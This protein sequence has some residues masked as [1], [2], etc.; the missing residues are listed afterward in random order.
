[1]LIWSTHSSVIVKFFNSS[2]VW[3]YTAH[4]NVGTSKQD[5]GCMRNSFSSGY[6]D[7]KPMSAPTSTRPTVISSTVHRCPPL[8]LYATAVSCEAVVDIRPN[9]T[10][11]AT[12]LFKTEF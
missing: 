12:F 6:C 3:S 7:R 5:K 11:R 4:A 9:S 2:V 8:P 1:M 10:A